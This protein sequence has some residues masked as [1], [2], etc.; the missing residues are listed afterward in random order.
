MT[1]IYYLWSE[2]IAAAW[3]FVCFVAIMKAAEGDYE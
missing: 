3:L 1:E 2:L